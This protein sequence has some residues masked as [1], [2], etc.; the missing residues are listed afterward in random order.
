[1]KDYIYFYFINYDF[2]S[3][4]CFYWWNETGRVVEIFMTLEDNNLTDEEN[5]IKSDYRLYQRG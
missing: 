5:P 3:G 4:E 2:Y 1:M